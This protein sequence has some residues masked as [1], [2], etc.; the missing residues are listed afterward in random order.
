M[1]EGCLP[2]EMMEMW[3]LGSNLMFCLTQCVGI[4]AQVWRGAAFSVAKPTLK[5][6]GGTPILQ[7]LGQ[8]WSPVASKCFLFHSVF[9][10]MEE[11]LPQ[12]RKERVC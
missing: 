7:K 5:L 4:Q 6:Q 3:F 1:L 12:K 10:T 8:P 11:S 2:I 9:I